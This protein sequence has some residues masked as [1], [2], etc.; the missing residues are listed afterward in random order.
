MF[1]LGDCVSLKQSEPF[2]TGPLLTDN[3]SEVTALYSKYKIWYKTDITAT[4]TL[5]LS[6]FCYM[7][8]SLRRSTSLG[9]VNRVL[10]VR[11]HSFYSVT[12]PRAYVQIIASFLYILYRN[13]YVCHLP[14]N[15]ATQS[16]HISRLSYS[17]T[18]IEID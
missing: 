11:S 17:K 4:F 10:R 15:R 9:T 13:A 8:F 1:A 7:F 6:E 3:T 12:P 16:F 5:R 14:T 18:T 2:Q